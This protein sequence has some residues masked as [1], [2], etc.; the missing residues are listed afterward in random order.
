MKRNRHIQHIGPFTINNKWLGEFNEKT[1]GV[2]VDIVTDR[3]TGRKQIKAMRTENIK[4]W[5]GELTVAVFR[6]T[7]RK[8]QIERSIGTDTER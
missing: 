2:V 6:I 8:E 7:K 5:T 1:Q 4:F 3:N